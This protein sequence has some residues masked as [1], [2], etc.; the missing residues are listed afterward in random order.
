LGAG[1]NDFLVI[2][3]IEA[4]GTGGLPATGTDITH[5]ALTLG[6]YREPLRFGEHKLAFKYWKLWT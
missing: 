6:G 3:R 4:L 5:Y 2:R 1:I